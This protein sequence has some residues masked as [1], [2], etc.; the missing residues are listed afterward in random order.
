MLSLLVTTVGTRVQQSILSWALP[1]HQ[2]KTQPRTGIP[3]TIHS[4]GIKSWLLQDCHHFGMAPQLTHV[5]RSTLV[6]SEKV[7]TVLMRWH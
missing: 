3:R 1:G 5:L 2:N 4:L 6:T 7:N